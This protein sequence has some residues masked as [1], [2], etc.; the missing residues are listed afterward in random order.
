LKLSVLKNKY[1]DNE[2]RNDEVVLI[3]IYNM[4]FYH[5]LIANT[6]SGKN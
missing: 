3:Y 4:P 2:P 6:Q 1:K 5:E